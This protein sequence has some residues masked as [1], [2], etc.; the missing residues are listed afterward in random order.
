M[1]LYLVAMT[2]FKQLRRTCTPV[3]VFKVSSNTQKC[4]TIQCIKKIWADF[5]KIAQPPH[6]S[7]LYVN[8][9]VVGG[10]TSCT[11]VSH[12]CS[13]HKSSIS[14][15]AC[16]SIE[17]WSGRQSHHVYLGRTDLKAIRSNWME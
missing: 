3:R 4:K 9:I 5:Y 15:T 1:S 10:Y 16:V 8:Y 12:F 13:L 7:L 17:T 11:H 14:Y 6:Y 2:P